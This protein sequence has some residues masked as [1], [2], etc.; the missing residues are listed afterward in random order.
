MLRSR[1][2]GA[3]R[4]EVYDMK[5]RLKNAKSQL[6]GGPE[7]TRTSTP[8]RNGLANKPIIKR[9]R[10]CITTYGGSDANGPSA[11]E[12]W[13]VIGT[14]EPTECRS[15]LRLSTTSNRCQQRYPVNSCTAIADVIG[16]VL[17][18]DE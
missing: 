2:L 11:P 12:I 16:E 3:R 6:D 1:P 17:S 18:E 9:L 15:G 7:N 4:M 8:T 14:V 10:R 13:Q 5:W